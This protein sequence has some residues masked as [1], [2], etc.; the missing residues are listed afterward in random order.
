M[1]VRLLKVLSDAHQDQTTEAQPEPWKESNNQ[2]VLTIQVPLSPLH[3][4]ITAAH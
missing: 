1:S 4:Y 2:L 3:K